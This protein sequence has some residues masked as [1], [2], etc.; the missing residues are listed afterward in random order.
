MLTADLSS[1]DLIGNMINYAWKAQGAFV[2][3]YEMSEDDFNSKGDDW[4]P[5][6]GDFR[7]RTWIDGHAYFL[8]RYTGDQDPLRELPMSAYPPGWGETDRDLNGCD[9]RCISKYPQLSLHFFTPNSIE[10]ELTWLLTPA[11][12]SAAAGFNAHGYNFNFTVDAEEYTKDQS[13]ALGWLTDL[14]RAP[15]FFN[16][17]IVDLTGNDAAEDADA[18]N[19]LLLDQNS[20]YGES[21]QKTLW[22]YVQDFT[23]M[24]GV[25][26]VDQ[27]DPEL[28]SIVSVEVSSRS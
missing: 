24:N 6:N 17:P 20:S 14:P 12:A 5:G 15:G 7:F 21:N 2:V 19:E 22:C 16:I 3:K 9:P 28:V 1:A 23:D 27:F 8:Q 11:V 26:F 10:F 13:T 18:L 4:K 25:K